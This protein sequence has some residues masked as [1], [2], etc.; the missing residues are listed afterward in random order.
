V[1]LEPVALRWVV[2]G[3][4]IA[5]ALPLW[6]LW[7][8]LV[9]AAWFAHIARPLQVRFARWMKK[10]ERGA[11]AATVLLVLIGLTPVALV[12]LSLAAEAA[13]LA[14]RPSRSQGARQALT[15]LVTGEQSPQ[16]PAEA[17]DIDLGT[18]SGIAREHG[19]SAFSTVTRIAGATTTAVIGLV[20]F[21]YG[22]Y[23]FLVRGRELYEWLSDHCPLERRHFARLAG[24]FMQTGRGLIIGF[25]LTSL[26]QGTVAAI[27][28]LVIG[29]P[30]ALVLGLLT[31]IAS[32]IPAIGTGLVWVPLAA[33]LGF[34]GSW[35][36][37]V[38]VLALGAVVSLGDNFL[39]P[40]LARYGKLD[41]PM[42]LLFVAMLGGF[43]AFG[44]W[45]LVLGPLL[46]RLAV[47]GLAMMR[48][49]T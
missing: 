7:A 27:G 34:S 19:M 18:V 20:V 14:E 33:G 2:L 29:L 30:S 9:L 39:R 36:Q 10:Q 3:L 44:A 16:P 47:E 26:V 38:A 46:I 48:E 49:Q 41:L 40:A 5:A 35:G 6:Q 31:A 15:A 11:A 22:F 32:L 43:A 24:A 12:S 8:P 1:A 37:A 17:T 45:G 23:V 21:V 13:D 25:G 4:V 42:F 28:Y